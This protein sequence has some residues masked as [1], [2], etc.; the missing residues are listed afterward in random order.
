MSIIVRASENSHWYTQDGEPAYTVKA[1]DGSDRPTTLRDAKKFLYVPSVTTILKCVANPGLDVWKQEQLL[2]SCLT[3]PRLPG[4]S[5]QAWINRIVS[6]SKETAKAAAERGTRIHES[7]EKHFLGEDCEYLELAQKTK[8]AIEDYFGVQQWFPE[9]SFAR[10]GYG[11][12]IDLHANGIVIDIKTKEFEEGDKLPEYDSHIMQL[13]AY[14]YGLDM[15]ESRVA[16]V[17]VSPSGVV[18]IKEWT[19][20]QKERG[21]KMFQ[22][23]KE[24]W[25]A[26]TGL[27]MQLEL[28]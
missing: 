18:A 12:K 9:K 28:D 14:A 10:Y 11:G 3:L 27:P 13:M 25:Y 17:F 6:D 2:L 20:D 23:I 21:W 5:E 8:Q 7:I 16:N 1:K 15:P 19:D 26:K 4:E 22:A 24:F